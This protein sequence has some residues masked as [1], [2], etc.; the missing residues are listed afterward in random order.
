MACASADAIPSVTKR[1]RRAALLLQRLALV[2]GEHED[3]RVEGRFVAPPAVPRIGSPGPGPAA[4]HVPA[5]HGRT[6]V[7]E[8]RLDDLGAG[9][10]LAALQPVRLAPDGEL[11]GPLVELVASLA[12]RVL[13]ARIGPGDEAVQRDRDVDLQL[14]H[15][16][17]LL[18]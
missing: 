16:A 5:H 11:D 7:R 8:R 13:L 12:Q 3:R 2:V 4:E 1:E 18:G 17:S 10:D 14:C 9:V 15:R 6:D